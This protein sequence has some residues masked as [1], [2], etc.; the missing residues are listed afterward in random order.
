MIDVAS[1]AE[2]LEWLA[3]WPVEDGNGDAVVELRPVYGLEDFEQGEGVEVHRQVD[4]LARRKPDTLCTYLSFDGN[5]RQAFEFY[6][7]CLGGE[8]E[9]MMDHSEAPAEF[10]ETWQDRIMHARL[11]VGALVLMGGDTPPGVYQGASGF[12]VQIGIPD[13]EQARAVFNEL[14]EGGTITMPFEQTFWAT[15]FGML[16]DRFGI[17]WM[18]N[19]ETD[20]G[21]AA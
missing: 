8:I 1:R 21:V 11:R 5:C 12:T 9:M 17:P 2:A 10:A 20:E 15:G 14:A 16:T 18:V 6:A 4:A 19:C 3:K 13:F 7:R